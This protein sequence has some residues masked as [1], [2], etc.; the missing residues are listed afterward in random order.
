VRET[1]RWS[2]NETTSQRRLDE[3]KQGTKGK[4]GEGSKAHMTPHPRS[5][6]L[7]LLS[8]HPRLT[9]HCVKEQSNKDL[10]LKMIR[11]VQSGAVRDATSQT[12]ALGAIGERG[13]VLKGVR[14]ENAAR[15]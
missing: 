10:K 9:T 12:T 8:I 13:D 2:C 11:Y 3:L 5:L 4:E 1:K 6:S 7:V 14:G 15:R